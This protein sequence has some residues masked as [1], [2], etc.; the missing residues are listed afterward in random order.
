MN[1]EAII[2]NVKLDFTNRRTT[3]VASEATKIS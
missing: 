2:A 1:R 3:I